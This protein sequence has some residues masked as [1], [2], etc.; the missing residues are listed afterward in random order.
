MVGVLISLLLMEK[1]AASHYGRGGDTGL[2]TAL[3]IFSC[4]A[5]SQSAFSE[6]FGLPVA[7]LGAAYYAGLLVLLP[8]GRFAGRG[9]GRVPDVVLGTSLF[10]VLL[11][12]FL[13]GVSLFVV[14]KLCP[15]CI[16][17]YLV[18]LG[19]FL[20]AWLGHADGRR[21]AFRTLLPLPLRAEAWIFLG[22][23]ALMTF[24][25]QTLFVQQAKTAR[26]Q[27]R[28]LKPES[29]TVVQIDLTDTPTR[30]PQDAPIT[31]VEFSDFQCP[32]CR[33]LKDSMD[34]AA[35]QHGNVKLAFI[36]FPMD[37]ACN[38]LIQHKF[39][40]HACDAAKAAVCAEK[41]GRFWEMY[42]ELFAHQKELDL[43]QL[44]DRALAIGL[45][46]GAFKTCLADATTLA[47]VQRDTQR[48]ADLK[49][50]GTP[51]WYVNGLRY[52]GARKSPDLLDIF[53][54]IAPPVA[55]AAASEP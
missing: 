29:T 10:A 24:G 53:S 9:F 27:N 6:I 23:M 5:A 44:P 33:L 55:G 32:Y 40:E 3:A 39:H 8:L 51:T 21:A 48:G 49:I 13:L 22:L 19:L 12:F 34:E 35:K 37:Q 30:G 50:E 2:C 14:G 31:V 45:D 25:G 15:L 46:A 7:V 11:S 52:V 43:D 28:G 1:H 36:Q 17:L 41:Q 42:E 18:D 47:R 54:Q 26:L 4:E 20:T 38:P 16:G